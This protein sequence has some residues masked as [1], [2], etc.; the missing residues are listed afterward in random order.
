MK[1]RYPALALCFVLSLLAVA[2]A[3]ADI[4]FQGD[5]DFADTGSYL[6]LPFDVP[7]GTTS[8]H[9]SYDYEWCSGGNGG[10][11]LMD[12]VVDIGLYDPE[13]FRGWSGSARSSF[14]LSESR[15]L[16]TDGYAPGEIVEGEWA[17]ELGVTLINPDAVVH[18]TVEVELDDA[19]VGAPFVWPVREDVVLASEARWYRGDL[20]CHSTHSDGAYPMEDVFDYASSIG[21]DFLAL[22]DHNGFSHMLTLGE[23]QA[24]YP[25]MLLLYGEEMTSYRGHANVFDL[26]RPVD[27]HGT[28]PG[29]DVNAVIAG[30]HED[31]GYF[32]PNHP[33]MPFFPVGE[34]FLGWGWAYPETDWS[35]VD[36]FEVVNGPSIVFGSIPNPLNR[37]A[38]LWWESLLDKGHRITAIGGSDDHAAGQ[39]SGD[40]YAPIGMPTTV[41]FAEELSA[42]ALFNA[43]SAG[44]VYILAA[45]P[46]GPV[47][48]FTASA[49]GDAAIPGDT[50][51][52]GEFEFRVEIAGALGM[53]LHFWKDGLP[54][55]R[56]GPVGIDTDP[57]V[58]GFHLNPARD[59]RI[60]LELKDGPYLAALTNPIFYEAEG[61]CA[62]M[63]ASPGRGNPL[64]YLALLFIPLAFTAAM[65]AR[66]GAVLLRKDRNLSAV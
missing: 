1:Q 37:L 30:V 20:H 32:S 5:F 6:L 43:I 57:F 22:T 8:I 7:V 51:S 31:G 33:A 19:P 35:G 23:M 15:D 45:G 65:R 48:D 26:Y 16:T 46:D 40:T 24:D 55:P 9:I 50:I 27:Y 17:V 4:E 29:Y 10:R 58:Y 3:R 56:H 36:F 59:G 62:A 25:E 64:P 34:S 49:G 39:G 14:T 60:R 52:G 21:L 44:H 2:A 13:K 63:P 61:L 47:I 18:Y 41:V 54:W 11:G 28:A 38:I 12:P 53:T 66:A 42:E